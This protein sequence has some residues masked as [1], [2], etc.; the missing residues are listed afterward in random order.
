MPA[1][2]HRRDPAT[3]TG[4]ALVK[5]VNRRIRAA[6]QLWKA[7]RN[8]A[9]RAERERALALYARLTPAERR[10]VPEQL[11][12]WLRFRSEKYFGSTKGGGHGAHEKVA[13]RDLPREGD[14]DG[15]TEIGGSDDGEDREDAD[16]SGDAD[17]WLD[18]GQ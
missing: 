13:K 7:H 8:A 17:E 10:Q 18:V 6:M 16:G 1:K 2:K 11:R 12:T 14:D 4:P 9:T 3:L 15:W 5:E